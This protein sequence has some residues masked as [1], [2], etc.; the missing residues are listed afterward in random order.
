MRSFVW[1]LP[2]AFAL[3]SLAAT[4][5][6]AQA[7]VFIPNKTADTADGTCNP[8]DCSLREAV[9]AANQ[10]PGEDVIILHA[11][12]YAL[13]LAGTGE[14]QA[15]TGDLDITGDLVVVGEGGASTA[16]DGAGL[17]RVLSVVSGVSLELNGVFL[18]NGRAQ[19]A[20]Q[21]G[22]AILNHG[23]LTITRSILSGNSSASGFGGAIY[24]DGPAELTIVDSTLSANVAN[25]GGGGIAIGG[26]ASLTNVTLTA[27]RSE[28]DFGGGL[29][30]FSDAEA[31]FNNVT[32]TANTAA[33]K[34]GGL[35]AEL[36]AF[37]G[38]APVFSNSILA[39]NFAASEPDCSG[40]ASS[41]GYNIVGIA[42]SCLS[43]S[44]AKNDKIGTSASPLDPKLGL[45]AGNGGPTPTQALLAGSPAIDAGNPALPGSGGTACAATDQRGAPRPGL[46]STPRCDS[47]AY[48]ITSGCIAGGSTLCLNDGRFKVTA[49]WRTL[50]STGP[51]E[52]VTLTGDTG[53]F[54]FFD[55]ANVEVTLKV[56][57]GCGLNNR[58]WVF[59]SGLTNVEV[60]LTVTDTQTGSVKTYLNPLNRTFRTVLDT[61]AFATCP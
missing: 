47:G 53:Y 60:T 2:A 41:A 14:D 56:L 61:N 22:G 33:Q 7:A 39:G 51:A 48:E 35:F 37:I 25:G 58:Y 54:W 55:P 34:G 5:P 21:N 45:L 43:F 16:I 49:T 1:T 44:A 12:V 28:T 40:S 10:N 15:A 59:L 50:D 3:L 13:T 46:Q 38:V 6:S 27:N 29:Y 32:I 20:I 57:N 24:T 26:T 9:L 11:G 17:D 23:T 18:R 42:S 8:A 31:T 4:A 36:S 52:G 19:G 30:V